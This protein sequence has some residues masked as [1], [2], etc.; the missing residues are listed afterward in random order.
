LAAKNRRRF[1]V[2]QKQGSEVRNQD[3]AP[4]KT[5]TTF[6]RVGLCYYGEFPMI[7]TH[8]PMNGWENLRFFENPAACRIDGAALVRQNDHG[9]KN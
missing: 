3:C 9:S 2:R 8:R 1:S 6:L 7:D 4:K 5:K